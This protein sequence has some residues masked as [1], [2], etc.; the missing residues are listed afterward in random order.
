MKHSTLFAEMQENGEAERLGY[1]DP[2]ELRADFP[3]FFYAQV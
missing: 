3:T 1:H 2:M